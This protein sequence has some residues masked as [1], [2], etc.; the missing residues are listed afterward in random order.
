MLEGR[1]TGRCRQSRGRLFKQRKNQGGTVNRRSRQ[2]KLRRKAGIEK[3]Q[4]RTV[5]KHAAGD[6]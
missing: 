4:A 2:I 1:D 3:R 6:R 5:Q